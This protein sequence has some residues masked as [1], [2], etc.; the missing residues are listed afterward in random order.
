MNIFVKAPAKVNLYLDII[1][2]D[3]VDNYHLLSTVIARVLKL[4]DEITI[5]PL[6]GYFRILIEIDPKS[7]YEVP[8]GEDNICF[9]A[10]DLLKQEAIASGVHMDKE[11]KLTP[12]KITIKKNIPVKAGLG[13]GSSDAAAVIKALNKLW[14]LNFPLRKLKGIAAK[15]SMDSSFFVEG[16]DFSYCTHFGEIVEPLESN[17]KLNID[18]VETNT[19]VETKWAYEN[20]DLSKC[21]QN[22]DKAR[23]MVGA[24]IDDDRDA[25]LA[26]L[27]ND[28]EYLIFEK[29]PKLHLMVEKRR[30]NGEHVILCGSGGCVAVIS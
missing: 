12:I 27:H 4:F 5:E 2:R 23:T 26:N 30:S 13:G 1:G 14:E 16:C 15:I 17:L 25:V 19:T 6:D 24:L 10:A 28:F 29:F 3:P 22:K 9:K 20:I 7:S 18:I 11:K 21:R 8:D